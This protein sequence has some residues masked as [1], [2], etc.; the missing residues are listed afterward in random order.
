MVGDEVN[1][2]SHIVVKV[3]TDLSSTSPYFGSG[4]LTAHE[5]NSCPNIWKKDIE[6]SVLK[7]FS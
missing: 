6:L 7:T 3:K 2:N 1:I 4:R 5:C